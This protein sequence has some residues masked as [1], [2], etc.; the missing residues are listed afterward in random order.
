MAGQDRAVAERRSFLAR[1]LTALGAW[2]VGARA[3]AQDVVQGRWSFTG[4]PLTTH[5]R[6]GDPPVQPLDTMLLFE[7]GDDNNDRAMTHEVLSLIHQ[8]RGR[9]SYPWTMYASLETHHEVGDACVVCSRLHKHGPGW[10]TGLHSE[11]FNHARMVALGVNIEMSN[12]YE[13]P[14][15]TQVIGLNIQAVGGPRPMQYGIQVHDGQGRFDKAIG[16]NGTGGVGLDI[17][18]RYEAGIHAHDN[19]IRLNEGACIVLDGEGR[20]RVRYRNGRVEF[21]NGD[22]CF[23]HLDVNGEDHAL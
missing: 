19:D 7:R 8:E 3:F 18:G 20:V 9:N 11:V 2:L 23:G 16:L 21:L 4:A 1:A 14:D 13:G 6:A 17:A 10:S 5:V 15:P 12:D 22:R